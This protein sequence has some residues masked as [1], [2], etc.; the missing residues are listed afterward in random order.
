MKIAV[1]LM[2]WLTGPT[3]LR[4]FEEENSDY[5]RILRKMQSPSCPHILKNM[6]EIGGG[7]RSKCLRCCSAWLF[8][9]FFVE[10]CSERKQRLSILCVFWLIC[11]IRQFSAV[12]LNSD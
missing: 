8:V 5:E 7:S 3:E 9:V 11:T 12:C 4:E 1:D 2:L 10:I 6:T